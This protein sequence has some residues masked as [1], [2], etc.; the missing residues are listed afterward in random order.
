MFC[1]GCIGRTFYYMLFM[2]AVMNAKTFLFVLIFNIFV[3]F[4]AEFSGEVDANFL[5]NLL[6]GG[7]LSVCSCSSENV[8]SL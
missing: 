4:G 3:S 8:S 5:C 7:K 2:S 1:S 6:R